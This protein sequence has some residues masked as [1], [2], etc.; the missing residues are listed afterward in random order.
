[1]SEPDV[2]YGTSISGESM[3]IIAESSGI[4]NLPDEGAKELADDISYRLKHIIQ[5]CHNCNNCFMMCLN[6]YQWK[7]IGLFC[8]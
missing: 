6:R 2:L 8:M 1:M 5:V 4:G 3:K 7:I